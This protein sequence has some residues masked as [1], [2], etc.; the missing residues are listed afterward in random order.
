MSLLLLCLRHKQLLAVL[1][2]DEGQVSSLPIDSEWSWIKIKHPA[3][4]KTALEDVHQRLELPAHIPLQVGLVYDQASAALLDGFA[5][6]RGSNQWQW[7]WLRWETRLA[8]LSADFAAETPPAPERVLNELLPDVAPCLLGIK[9]DA[10]V[11]MAQAQDATDWKQSALELEKA[12]QLL[13]ARLD[14]AQPLEAEKLLSYLPA[15]YVHVF[16][17]IGAAELALLTGRVEP[18]NLPSPYPEPGAETLRRKQREFQLLPREEQAYIVRLVS[19]H[20]HRLQPRAEM[21]ALI[22]ELMQA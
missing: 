10:P 4:L 2:T 15:L 5:Q 14:M 8:R 16:S 19:G 3:S 1:Q 9:D 7:Q 18:F 11:A 12:N 22:S 13:R 21:Q 6:W 20:I 17:V